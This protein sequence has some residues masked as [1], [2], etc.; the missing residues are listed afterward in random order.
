MFLNPNDDQMQQAQHGKSKFPPMQM[1]GG[2][3]QGTG[4]GLAPD[5]S[6]FPFDDMMSQ[7]NHL[8]ESS[9][10]SMNILQGFTSREPS[11]P[12]KKR[13]LTPEEKRQKKLAAQA[14]AKDRRR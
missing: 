12:S 5:T 10:A 9:T 3:A 14:I 4:I 13:K 11:R 2:A 6:L 8:V 1:G 7:N